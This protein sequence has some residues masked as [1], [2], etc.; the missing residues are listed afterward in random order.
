MDGS[1]R[2]FNDYLQKLYGKPIDLINNE[3]IDDVS[4][5]QSSEFYDLIKSI[6]IR[7]E[8]NKKPAPPSPVSSAPPTPIMAPSPV[9]SVPPSPVSSAPPT[10]VSSAPA[11]PIMAPVPAP[12]IKP[13]FK[14]DPEF[15]KLKRQFYMSVASNLKIPY[16]KK[17]KTD[18][19]IKLLYDDKDGS[20]IMDYYL[21]N[22]NQVSPYFNDKKINKKEKKEAI[23]RTIEQARNNQLGFG[24]KTS[25]DKHQRSCDFRQKNK[26][27][28]PVGLFNQYVF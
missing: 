2:K 23:L 28:N 27:Q 12:D 16:G 14:V 26:Y 1:S 25:V 3:L 24:M 4:Y 15:K 10:P 13:E 9:S 6:Q 22:M 21:S 20:R 19:L 8:K 11:T 17:I 18:E 5:Y 7:E